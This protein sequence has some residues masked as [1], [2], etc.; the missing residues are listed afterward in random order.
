MCGLVSGSISICQM[1]ILAPSWL[2][3]LLAKA[4]KPV[5]LDFRKDTIILTGKKKSCEDLFTNEWMEQFPVYWWWL[6]FDFCAFVVLNNRRRSSDITVVLTELNVTQSAD[7][8]ISFCLCV[9]CPVLMTAFP[10]SHPIVDVFSIMRSSKNPQKGE[11]PSHV[12]T[13]H[14]T[15]RWLLTSC[16]KD[17]LSKFFIWFRLPGS[18]LPSTVWSLGQFIQNWGL[19]NPKQWEHWHSSVKEKTEIWGH[20]DRGCKIIR[21]SCTHTHTHI[22]YIHL[23]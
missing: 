20:T 7:W 3:S 16:F 8:E 10:T 2:F 17:I 15:P 13:H 18:F 6:G 4:T 23:H 21:M 5:R 1:Y 19:K 9:L 22:L 14:K 12:S 11:C